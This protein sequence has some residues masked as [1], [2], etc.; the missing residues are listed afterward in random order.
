[1]R[2]L[3]EAL[4]IHPQDPIATD[5]LNRALEVSADAEL[6]LLVSDEDQDQF[7]RQMERRMMAA[8]ARTERSGQGRDQDVLPDKGKAAM[9]GKGKA[10]NRLGHANPHPDADEYDDDRT[11]SM[12]EMADD[13]R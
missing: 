7:D 11:G 3:H 5:L 6:A 13:D 2:V 1:V 10:V 9:K 12:M 4:A 8:R